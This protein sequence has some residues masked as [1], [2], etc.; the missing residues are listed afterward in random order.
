MVLERS[1]LSLPPGGA[2][3]G[4]A[5]APLAR[6]LQPPG[7]AVTRLAA[8]PGSAWQEVAAAAHL[9]LAGPWYAA[10]RN[11]YGHE[12]LYLEARAPQGAAVLPA[13]V[14]RRPLLGTV[15]A[16]MPFLDAGGPAGDPALAGPL[17]AR[18]RREAE[19]CG[20]ALLEVRSLVPLPLPVEPSLSKITLIRRLA[21][22]PD[23]VWRQLP[24]TVR[25][26]VRKAENSGVSVEVGGAELLEAF[27]R[28]FAVN[29]RDLGSP[30][31]GRAFFRALF[32]AFGGAA[33]IVLARRQGRP[34]G[35]LYTLV[36]GDT[37]SAP[38]ASALRAEAV[39]SPN[40]L[41]YWEALRLGCRDG[42]AAF[43]FGRSTVDSGTHRFKRQWGTQ[44]HQLY[45][46]S[47]PLGGRAVTVSAR[48]GHWDLLS[49]VWRLLPVGVTRL[50][51]PPLRRLLSQ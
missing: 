25:N 28:V 2:G 29:M 23:T 8:P 1:H 48:A 34:V 3:T 19:A 37:L 20:A 45:W 49:R 13:F 5:E 27:Y 12:P 32:Q 7:L 14:L 9:A 35:G 10:I 38:W 15:V 47:L 31:H 46:Y 16:S 18:L 30:V 11:A 4:C 26:R 21:P 36:H 40:T 17:L 6:A 42:L 44:P 51:G 39:Y 33:R 24:A 41:C 50:L 22:D 43:D